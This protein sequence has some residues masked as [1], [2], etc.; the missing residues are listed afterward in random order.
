[1]LELTKTDYVVAGVTI[2]ILTKTLSYLILP[3]RRLPPG[4]PADPII[5]H[6]RK[7]PLDEPY[8]TYAEWGKQY[9][10]FYDLCANC[11]FL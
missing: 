11:R 1:M 4:P 3:S 7:I 9:G 2:F 5:G 10:A 6:A 8:R